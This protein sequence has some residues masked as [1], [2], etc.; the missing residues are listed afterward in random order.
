MLRWFSLVAYFVYY[1]TQTFLYPLFHFITAMEGKI[2]ESRFG[3]TSTN[4]I[5]FKQPNIWNLQ[6]SHI[7]SSEKS[8]I[9]PSQSIRAWAGKKLTAAK[10]FDLGT[11]A[12]CTIEYNTY[13]KMNTIKVLNDQF[14]FFND[15]L[16]GQPQSYVKQCFWNDKDLLAGTHIPY[17]SFLQHVVF[18]KERPTAAC[19]IYP[20]VEVMVWPLGGEPSQLIM[21]WAPPL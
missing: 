17:V 3:Q 11:N 4:C 2:I 15:W 18:K 19:G 14:S 9:F 12:V 21:K 5:M 7:N 20:H 1:G 6:A 16:L 13:N 8:V 10:S